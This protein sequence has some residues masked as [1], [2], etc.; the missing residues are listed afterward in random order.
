MKCNKI[1]FER[2]L[3]GF[4]NNQSKRRGKL[5]KELSINSNLTISAQEK[6]KINNRKSQLSQY[7]KRTPIKFNILPNKYLTPSI[8]QNI[9]TSLTPR[10]E[11]NDIHDKLAISRKDFNKT[12][13]TNSSRNHKEKVI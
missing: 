10:K 1:P 5:A 2:G 13:L 11:D 7:I 6:D 9:S 8:N 12:V 4:L 3:N